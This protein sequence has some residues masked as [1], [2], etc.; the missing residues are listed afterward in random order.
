MTVVDRKSVESAART[1]RSLRNRVVDGS[2]AASRLAAWDKGD[3]KKRQR[4]ESRSTA[5][6]VD[7]SRNFQG[8]PQFYPQAPSLST[9]L[10]VP[11]EVAS[12]RC[13]RADSITQ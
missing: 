9:A 8:Y 2:V 11:V 5:K 6:Q 4:A 1:F 13:G 7:E 12:G 10:S 3:L